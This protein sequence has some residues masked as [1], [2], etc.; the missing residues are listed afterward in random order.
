MNDNDIGLAAKAINNL[1]SI[2]SKL[3]NQDINVFKTIL[4]SFDDTTRNK[5][6]NYNISEG[7]GGERLIHQALM[8]H[9]DIEIVKLFI[10]PENLDMIHHGWSVLSTITCD[11]FYKNISIV[12]L[13]SFITNKNVNIDIF[14]HII[15]KDYK[16]LNKLLTS[17]PTAELET[18]KNTNYYLNLCLNY[19]IR[20]IE[21]LKLFTNNSTLHLVGDKKLTSLGYAKELGITDVK[22]LEFLTPV[23]VYE[24][25][26]I[27]NGNIISKTVLPNLD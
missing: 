9:I 2:Q 12:N 17:L 3:K 19:G 6:L 15:M 16:F 10:T 7:S 27:K 5:I 13:N 14:K 26:I 23:D 22:V 21:I 24:I 11:N 18:V 25:A 4:N 20:D 1:I 8:C